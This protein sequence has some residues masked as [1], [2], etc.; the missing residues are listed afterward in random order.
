M[1]FV[2]TALE[3]DIPEDVENDTDVMSR[4]AMNKSTDISSVLNTQTLTL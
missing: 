2:K 3:T 4:K 1:V